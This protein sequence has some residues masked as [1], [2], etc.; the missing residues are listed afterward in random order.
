MNEENANRAA[1]LIERFGRLISSESHTEGLQPVQWEVLRYLTKANR[2][3]QTAAAVT[4]YLGITKGTV[5]QTLKTLEAKGLIR[6]R[7]DSKDRRSNHLKLTTKGQRLISK[8]PLESVTSAL[9]NLDDQRAQVLMESLEDTLR[10]VLTARGRQPFG[11]CRNCVYFAALHTQGQPHFCQLLTQPL[12]D[13]DAQLLCI[14]QTPLAES[15]P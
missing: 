1:A 3:S 5:S 9:R 8:G 15:V 2:F 4:A 11:Q 12:T 6:K 7:V 10:E 14:E 13:A